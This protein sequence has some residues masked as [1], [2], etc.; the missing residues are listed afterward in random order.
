MIGGNLEYTMSSL[1]YLTFQ[2]SQEARTKVVSL[3]RKY[4]GAPEGEIDLISIFEA[5]AAKFLTPKQRRVLE[6]I[7]LEHI[8]EPGF[9]ERGNRVLASFSAYRYQLKSD[10]RELRILRRSGLKVVTGAKLPL[11]PG[12]P[13]EE[14]VQLMRWQ[15]EKLDELSIGRYADFGALCA[16]K[17]KLLLLQRLWDFDREK[18]FE[19]FERIT[20]TH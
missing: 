1:P 9:Q 5:E 10:L 20:K 18:G 13:L 8:H 6:E 2:A 12:S 4:A 14:E 7:D 15:W 19:K 11:A 16:Y 3:I 17:L